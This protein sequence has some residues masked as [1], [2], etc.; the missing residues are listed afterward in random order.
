MAEEIT[1][2]QLKEIAKTPKGRKALARA[3]KEFGAKKTGGGD[4]KSV[5]DVGYE[6]GRKEAIAA[7][8]GAIGQM[9]AGSR[10]A[11]QREDEYQAATLGTKRSKEKFFKWFGIEMGDW[12]KRHLEKRVS[13]EEQAA[14]REK[15]GLDKKEKEKKKG[16]GD[17]VITKNLVKDVTQIKNI[18][19]S[20]AKVILVN[21]G[22]TSEID[23]K[24]G[25]ILYRKGGKFVKAEEATFANFKTAAAAAKDKK[26]TIS[27]ERSKSLIAKIMSDEDPQVR[28]ADTLDAIL[29]SLGQ[30]KS[31]KTVHEK[32]DAGGG[33]GGLGG[34]TDLLGKRGLARGAGRVLARALTRLA[35]PGMGMAALGAG[36]SAM[37][38]YGVY[39][40]SGKMQKDQADKMNAVANEYGFKINWDE[41]TPAV[42]TAKS[43]EIGGKKYDR[44]E[45]L[46]QEYQNIINANSGARNVY[47][48]SA[49]QDMANNPQKYQAIKDAA[50]GGKK[51]P[52]AGGW[53]G[54]EKAMDEW[55][56]KAF[57]DRA[58]N[59]EAEK[60]Y[61]AYFD[62]IKG[63]GEPPTLEKFLQ[64]A[65]AN[66]APL[67]GMA[68]G[69]SQELEEVSVTSQRLA[70]PTP[71]A[72]TG[73]AAEMASITKEGIQH[74]AAVA[75][76][77]P[78]PTPTPTPT[79][80]APK[81]TPAPPPAVPAG[82]KFKPPSGK[83]KNGLLLPPEDVGD[84]I[85]NAAAAVGVDQGI[86]LAMA[87]QESGFKPTAKAGTS[88]ASGLYQFIDST[89]DSM[90]KK[91]GKTYP[92]LL[93]GRFD[94]NASAIAG[95]LFIKENMDILKKNGISVDGTSIYA[96]HF[97]GPGGAL[98]L[99]SANPLTAAVDVLGAKVAAANKTIFYQ[100]DG[101][102][103]ST[104][105]DVQQFLYNKVGKMSEMYAA[106]VGGG[107]QTSV[108]SPTPSTRVA[109]A[110]SPVPSTAGSAMS[111]QSNEYQNTQM[112]AANMPAAAGPVVVNNVSNSTP[113]TP[114]A[115]LP[116]AGTRSDDNSFNRALAK[117]FAHP[118]AFS[119]AGLA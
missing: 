99:F 84:A 49:K 19:Q 3:L 75:P 112:V 40:M 79:P 118:T 72:P 62:S 117:D 64:D 102:T 24:T 46:P 66:G 2:Q 31:G 76:P 60:I 97:L 92:D 71:T 69:P 16:T 25:K 86:M 106:A 61:S 32:L 93:K 113:P 81:P 36:T 111:A 43:F 109:S 107:P 73:S 51:P 101:K 90:V 12:A 63:K 22:Y 45:D 53:D 6:E 88:S 9:I 105:A 57:P 14:A 23:P 8:K 82:P 29:K 4:R 11:S 55:L 5:Y 89:W 68:A 26:E 21:R 78:K 87:K 10:K 110:V 35:T 98:K 33:G 1:D 50:K 115:P 104:I 103:P 47:A 7:G 67:G 48:D 13:P 30:D 70:V 83:G 95:A 108:S 28:I 59:K 74:G 119:S 80:P 114:K 85:K 54:L 27:K 39:R 20:L 100:K 18:V 77:A 56:R 17:G 116:K 41:S 52:A 94:L 42:P 65:Q 58:A 37:M 15:L 96:S 44:F 34:L 38:A 91:Y